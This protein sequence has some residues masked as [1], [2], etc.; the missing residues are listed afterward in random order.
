MPSDTPERE[1]NIPLDE[2]SGLPFPTHRLKDIKAGDNSV[3]LL[4][5]T[6]D[7]LYDAAGV[8]AGTDSWQI[9][10]AWDE[11]ALSELSS[12]LRSRP[13]AAAPGPGQSAGFKTRF[14]GGYKL[15]NQ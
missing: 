3:Q 9:I 12:L 2:D 14:G 11:S 4:V 15:G 5:S 10:G 6:K 1:T 7:H 8:E 13:G